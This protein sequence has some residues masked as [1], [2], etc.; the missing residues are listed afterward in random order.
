M[1]NC[2]IHTPLF[3]D[4]S[5]TSQNANAWGG[6]GQKREKVLGYCREKGMRNV[7]FLISID[8]LPVPERG[9]ENSMNF[10]QVE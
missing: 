7:D 6:R 9:R 3:I 5:S 2:C 4:V 8:T 1:P 10:I